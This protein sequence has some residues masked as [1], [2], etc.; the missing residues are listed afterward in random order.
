MQF[1]KT[2]QT[3]FYAPLGAKKKQVL[4]KI[5]QVSEL[6]CYEVATFQIDFGINGKQKSLVFNRAGKAIG[7][8]G[9]VVGAEGGGKR[10]GKKSMREK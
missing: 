10:L 7:S 3:V 9:F 5:Y 6:N 2:Y 1:M 8:I 4:G